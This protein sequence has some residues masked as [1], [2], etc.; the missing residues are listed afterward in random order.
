MGWYKLKIRL[1][2]RLK[3]LSVC[4]YDGSWAEYIVPDRVL[5]VAV[6]ASDHQCTSTTLQKVTV[7]TIKCEFV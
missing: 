2:Y 6:I 1:K 3:N 7:V 5:E 4:L